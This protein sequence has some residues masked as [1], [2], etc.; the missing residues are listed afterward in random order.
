MGQTEKAS[1]YNALKAAGHPFEKPYRNYTVDELKTLCDSALGPQETG[2]PPLP[3][4]DLR[5]DSP[6]PL[7]GRA[8]RVPARATAPIAPKDPDEVAGARTN[9]NPELEPIRIDPETGYVWYQEEVRKPAYPKPR[10]R[11]ILRVDEQ[12]AVKKSVQVGEYTEEFE[13]AGNSTGR[14]SEIKI[15]LPSYQVGIYKD[16]RFPFKIYCYNENK[17]FDYFEVNNYYGGKELVPST[18]KRIYVENTLCYD[19]PSVVQAI[20]REFRELQLQKRI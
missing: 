1:Y 13:V 16:P 9:S 7:P 6:P 12:V 10:G 2:P 11:R 14:T 18:I 20:Q 8:P 17:G 19:I 5:F 4:E 3:R 15:T